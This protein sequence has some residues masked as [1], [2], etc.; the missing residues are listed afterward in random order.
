MLLVIQKTPAQF[1]DCSK[2]GKLKTWLGSPATLLTSSTKA[3]RCTSMLDGWKES[4]DPCLL[5]DRG[6]PSKCVCVWISDRTQL[7]ILDESESS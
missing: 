3:S 7:G 6:T 4:C 1:H 5:E 2:E